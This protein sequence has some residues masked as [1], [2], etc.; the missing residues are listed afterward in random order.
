V[1]FL[2]LF[3]LYCYTFWRSQQHLDKE[4]QRKKFDETIEEPQ[5]D[6]EEKSLIKPTDEVIQPEA[7]PELGSKL[8]SEDEEEEP[9]MKKVEQFCCLVYWPLKKVL[10]VTRLPEI[11]LVLVFFIIYI[12]CEFIVTIMNVL[13]V[14]T[15]M[16]HFLVGLT[17]MVWGSDVLEL[18][19]MIIATNKKQLELGLTAVLAC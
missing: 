17:L 11:A 9:F 12:I 13:S 18:F 5:K 2:C 6:I 8:E 16:S 7:T 1:L 15:N 4:A 10:P 19:N 14:Y 3:F